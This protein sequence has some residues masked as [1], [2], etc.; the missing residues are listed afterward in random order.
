[1]RVLYLCGA[2]NPEGVRLALRVNEN[3]RLWDRIMLLDNNPCKIGQR[4]L[5]VRTEGLFSFLERGDPQTGSVANLVTGTTSRRWVACKSIQAFGRPFSPLVHP[6]TDLDGVALGRDVLVHKWDVLG[7]EVT[8]GDSSVIFMGAIIGHESQ[9][10]QCCVV[11]PNAVLN[12]RVRL[13]EGAYIGANVTIMPEIN[14]SACATV[15]AGSVVT[16]GVPECSTV[17]GIP[18]KILIKPDDRAYLPAP[19]LYQGASIRSTGS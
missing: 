9:L 11:A 7:P 1:L 18:A 3:P 8:V 6:E 10:S 12:A 17:M 19:G 16:Q 4:I 5:G 14:I 13:G 15:V 2:D